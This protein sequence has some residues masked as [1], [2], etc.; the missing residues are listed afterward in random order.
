MQIYPTTDPRIVLITSSYHGY[1]VDVDSCKIIRKLN[2]AL[3]KYSKNFIKVTKRNGK[4][5]HEF[6][7][8]SLLG[9]NGFT[10][11]DKNNYNL[12]TD[13]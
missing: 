9:I 12:Q 11:F 5:K 8:Y 10:S 2:T 1:V 3:P 4:L 13:M 7:V 6:R